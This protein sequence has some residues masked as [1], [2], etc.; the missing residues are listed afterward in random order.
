[1]KIAFVAQPID[2]VLPPRQNSIGIWIYEVARRIASHHDVRVYLRGTG[3][4]GRRRQRVAG[5]DYRYVPLGFDGRLL[6]YLKRFPW[7]FGPKRPLFASALYY[8]K[9][10]LHIAMDLR[11]EQCDI[12][13]VHN[14]SQFIPIIKKFNP[15]VKTVLHM[16]CEWLTQ[17][18]RNMIERRLRHADLVVS[19]SNYITQKI[20]SA[21]PI[22]ATRCRTIYNGVD[23][24]T[25]FPGKKENANIA[26]NS[27]KRLLFIGRISPEKGV[28]IL[29]EA[30]Q[31]ILKRYPKAHL[32]L[33]GPQRP[34]PL[35]YVVALSDDQMVLGLAS[36]Y[37]NGYLSYLDKQ[38]S[39]ELGNRVTFTKYIPH[40]HLNKYYRDSDIFVF[41]SVWNE[42]FGMPIIEAMASGLPVVATRGGGIPE[43]V[44]DGKTGFLVERGDSKGLSKS[45]LTLLQD[46]QL[47]KSISK[48]G[49]RR[50]LES[51]SW[52]QIS[53]CL[54]S[55]YD[56]LVY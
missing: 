15:K 55:E 38:L 25:F 41:S 52:E 28:H 33:I 40:S 43:I 16:H 10:I 30:F 8:L 27:R 56:R 3:A 5:V 18:D 35:E 47:A 9:Y 48:A 42:P 1:M 54:I 36:F 17:L 50:V 7:P 23:V 12:V 13:H 53:E 44:E 19:C 20:R 21:F 49:S 51:F 22:F 24:S 4:R 11:K 46:R 34:V 39:S 32:Q 2:P 45:I 37:S 26:D 29:L 14:F 6:P 31:K